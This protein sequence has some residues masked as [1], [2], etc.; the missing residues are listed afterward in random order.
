M[1]KTKWGVWCIAM[2]L[3]DIRFQNIM[4]D[5]IKIKFTLIHVHNSNNFTV[6]TIKHIYISIYIS[7]NSNDTDGK[8]E[9]DG[10][11]D[12]HNNN[13]YTPS[14][15]WWYWTYHTGMTACCAPLWNSWPDCRRWPPSVLPS[16]CTKG[17]QCSHVY[18]SLHPS[19]DP[20]GN[21]SITSSSIDQMIHPSVS[22]ISHPS[23][24]Q[25]IMQLS[26]TWSI[27]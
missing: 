19:S 14:D 6:N 16:A 24:H 21:K 1:M 26:W 18:Q 15:S 13:A 20:A 22:E 9:S 12:D 2:L 11:E 4:S 8:N 27:S 7:N 3:S 23:F 25:P 10:D 5:K 17:Q